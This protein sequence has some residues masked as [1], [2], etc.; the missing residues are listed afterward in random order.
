MDSSA[1]THAARKMGPQAAE[2]SGAR[3]DQVSL[4]LNNVYNTNYSTDW[5]ARRLE[6]VH[7]GP[8]LPSWLPP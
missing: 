2:K 3:Y 6:P 4:P 5:P 7:D 1:I 8:G